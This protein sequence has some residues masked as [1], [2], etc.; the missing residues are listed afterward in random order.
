MYCLFYA[1]KEREK[2]EDEPRPR[3]IHY[4]GLGGSTL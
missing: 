2:R 4:E 3:M 1:E